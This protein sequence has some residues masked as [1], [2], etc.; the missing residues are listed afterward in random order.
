[1][2]K[3]TLVNT[4]TGLGDIQTAEVREDDDKGRHTTTG[5]Q[6]HRLRSGGWLLDT[7][8]MR[9]LQLTDA[10]EG[11]NDVFADIAAL[12]RD[13]KFSDCAHATEPG[14]AVTAAIKAGALDADRVA[15]WQKLLAEDAFNTRTLTERRSR[16]KDLGRMIRRIQKDSRK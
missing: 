5:R 6:L 11:V 4:L 16:D 9:E 15:R 12:A 13:C 14:C 2:G 7:P 10:S 1:V 8:G 3:S